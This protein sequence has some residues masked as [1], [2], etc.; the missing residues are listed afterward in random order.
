[1][2]KYFFFVVLCFFAIQNPLT[3]QISHG[4]MPYGLS[5]AD[6]L[7]NEIPLISMPFVD[8]GALRVEDALHN[9][10]KTAWRFGHEMEVGINL[11][12]AGVWETLSN[13]DRIWRVKIYSK[14]ARMLNLQY[15]HFYMPPGARFHLYSPDGLS[16]LGAFTHANNKTHGQFATGFIYGDITILEYYEPAQVAE[17]GILQVSKVIHGYR[18]FGTPPLE[19]GFNDSGNCNNNVNCPEA[20]DWQNEKRAVGLIISGG[21]RA[22]TGSML[23]GVRGDCT[24]FFITANH[25]LGGNINQWMVMF[26]YESPNCAN[27]DGPTNQLVSG[28]TL[29]ANSPASDFALFELSAIPPPDY[30]VYYAG[31]SVENIAASTSVAIHHPSGDVKKISFNEDPL[32][33]IQGNTGVSGAHWEVTEWEDGTTEGGSSGSPIYDQNHHFVGQLFGGFASCVNTGGY[34]EYG[35]FAISWDYGASSASRAKDWLDPDNTGILVMDG[36]N[37]GTPDFAID[38]SVVELIGVESMICNQGAITPSVVIRNQGGDDLT[39]LSISYTLNGG[40]PVS[41]LWTGSL[42]YFQNETVELPLI[43]LDEP[44]E[45]L[46]TVTV[47]SPNGTTDLNFVNNI[48][49]RSFEV[50]Q[51][52]FLTVDLNTDLYGEE[53]TFVIE[54]ENGDTLYIGESFLSSRNYLLDYCLAAGCYNFVISDSENDGICCGFGQGN[55]SLSSNGTLLFESAGNFGSSESFAFCIEPD[56]VGIE[57]EHTISQLRVAVTNSTLTGNLQI[58]NHHPIGDNVLL[59]IYTISGRKVFD[60]PLKTGDNNFD[61]NNTPLPKGVYVIRINTNEGALS[62]KLI[63]AGR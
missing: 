31:W 52:D 25:C 58:A 8:V 49:E 33:S 43:T 50:V 14:N 5:H 3:A 60:A 53:T 39:G 29:L 38:A 28:M 32:V 35:K 4:G 63:F 17:Q 48:I 12:N 10:T 9:D 16:K 1:M 30:N 2:E 47:T 57:E 45:Y 11:Q 51:G 56:D 15:E 44:G 54:S 42:P 41:I 46:L 19:K 22:C 13:G 34:D 37:C 6:E 7:S 61:L 18:G 20:A 23:N 27:V 55:Y 62:Q 21:S 36:R 59:E 40:S 24:P 26:N